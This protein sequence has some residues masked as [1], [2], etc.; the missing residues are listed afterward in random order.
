MGMVGPELEKFLSS[1]T[2]TT[3]NDT[4]THKLLANAMA[5]L[6]S[7]SFISFAAIS[8]PHARVK[9]TRIKVISRIF[10]RQAKMRVSWKRNFSTGP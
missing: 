9:I 4:D 5:S 10:I 6:S 7:R 8:S 2:T 1:R 3:T